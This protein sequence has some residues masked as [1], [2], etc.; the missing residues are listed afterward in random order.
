MKQITRIAAIRAIFDTPD[1]SLRVHELKKLTP[2]DIE[3]L[4]VLAAAEL[5]VELIRPTV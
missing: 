2:D 5:G 1:K 3:E 4:A